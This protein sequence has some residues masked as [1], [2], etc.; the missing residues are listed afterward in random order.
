[1]GLSNQRQ[2]VVSCAVDVDVAAV[3]AAAV[4]DDVTD[5]VAVV[6]VTLL[7]CSSS[8]INAVETMSLMLSPMLTPLF[9]TSLLC[10][11][12]FGVLLACFI[13][14]VFFVVQF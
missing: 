5:V 7:H 14:C 8:D 6:F 13:V 9:E 12:P 3:T 2:G 11:H 4:C 10:E 1:M